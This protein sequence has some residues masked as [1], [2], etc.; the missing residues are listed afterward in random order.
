VQK[1]TEATAIILNTSKPKQAVRSVRSLLQQETSFTLHIVVVDNSNLQVN[2]KL[3]SSLKIYPNVSLLFLTKNGYAYGN[4]RGEERAEGE[5]LF[6]VNP[7]IH[8]PCKNTLQVMVDY[9]EA[10]SQVVIAG[11]KQ[12]N[13]DGSVEQT[14]RRFPTFFTQMLRRIP[15]LKNTFPVKHYEYSDRDISCIQEVDWLQS[16][17]WAVKRSFWKTVGGFDEQYFIFMADVE[18]CY[19]A[20]K[21]GKKVIFF[22]FTSIQ[23]DGIRCSQGNLLQM[24]TKKIIRIHMWDAM[25]FHWNRLCKDKKRN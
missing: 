7:D 8:F 10:H 21:E 13:P 11:P 1:I 15:F 25:K 18:M 9:M 19:Q 16:S 12:I 23:A 17:F 2:K 6:I 22:P 20:K 3:L 4:N 5:I 14:S 24:C